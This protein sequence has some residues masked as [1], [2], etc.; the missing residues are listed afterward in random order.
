MNFIFVFILPSIFGFKLIHA[1]VDKK[2]KLNLIIYGGMLLLINNLL[3]SILVLFK[4]SDDFNIV[5]S[6][7]NSV[8][9]S[10][11]YIFLS[12]FI[13]CI[14]GLLIT[15]FDKYLNINVEVKHEKKKSTKNSK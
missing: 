1:N 12:I 5:Y 9:M 2:N 7:T 11:A 3:T 13:G 6:A 8:K 4:N 15:I 14:V 10:I